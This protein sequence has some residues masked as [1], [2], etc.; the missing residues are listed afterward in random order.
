MFTK[1]LG[2]THKVDLVF[3]GMTMTRTTKTKTRAARVTISLLCSLAFSSCNSHVF[4]PV[5]ECSVRAL[6]ATAIRPEDPKLDILIVMDNSGTMSQEQES[7]RAA[8]LADRSDPGNSCPVDLSVVG[9]LSEEACEADRYC[10]PSPQVYE[11]E[12]RS[13][14]GFLDVLSAYQVDFNIGLLSMDM[15]GCERTT[16][17][18]SFSVSGT[19]PDTMD[20][21]FVIPPARQCND[22]AL[23]PNYIQTRPN[24]S[25]VRGCLRAMD[26]N[27]VVLSSSSLTPQN[28]AAKFSENLQALSVSGW[29]VE[30]GLESAKLFLE[31]GAGQSSSLSECTGHRDQLIREGAQLLVVFV[32]DEDDCSYDSES[33]FETPD[34]E[35][36]RLGIPNTIGNQCYLDN[37]HDG[38]GNQIG[39]YPDNLEKL[40]PQYNAQRSGDILRDLCYTGGE[41]LY[42]TRRY[43]EFFKELNINNEKKSVKLAAIIGGDESSDGAF[44]V[45]GCY[46]DRAAAGSGVR[47]GCI[48]GLGPDA[49]ELDDSGQCRI[50]VKPDITQQCGGL[51][52]ATQGSIATPGTT[53]EDFCCSA[54]SGSRYMDVLKGLEDPSRVI[55]SSICNKNFG[56]ALADIARLGAQFDTVVLA[57]PP[58]VGT[59]I[60]VEVRN[61]GQAEGI[62]VPRTDGQAAN[63][64]GWDFKDGSSNTIQLFGD[65]FVPEPGGIISVSALPDSVDLPASEEAALRA[66]QGTF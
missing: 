28:L 33:D 29:S 32:T 66:C 65:E 13:E 17:K 5:Q 63:P 57:E 27:E 21:T 52:T 25:Q 15:A 60:T 19:D 38:G 55:A 4:T 59:P 49:G 14:C 2:Q 41:Y 8:F 37:I 56:S 61:P 31:T 42:S 9:N 39:Q 20:P 36:V 58:K 12:I 35:R 22:Y 62:T 34:G 45:G 46:T 47:T 26:G 43:S 30:Q 16:W 3:R 6:D 1:G 18:N 44:E 51:L 53:P 23:D 24:V 64:Y 50:E 10:K 54:D 48:D 11:N 40:F 7:V